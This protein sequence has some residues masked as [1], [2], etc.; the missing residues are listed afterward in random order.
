MPLGPKHHF[1]NSGLELPH[2]GLALLN[3]VG[4]V[5]AFSELPMFLVLLPRVLTS[6]PSTCPRLTIYLLHP[7][8][9]LSYPSRAPLVSSSAPPNPLLLRGPCIPPLLPA[10]PPICVSCLSPAR[11]CLFR[12]CPFIVVSFLYPSRGCSFRP[13]PSFFSSMSACHCVSSPGVV[14]HC[15]S[16][17]AIRSRLMSVADMLLT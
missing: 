9:L 15:S 3:L 5:I 7:T 12:P 1:A 16:C 2:P 11:R 6:T 13:C 8:P 17:C 14:F 10:V 4:V